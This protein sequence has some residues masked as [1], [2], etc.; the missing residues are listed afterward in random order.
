MRQGWGPPAVSGRT[1][2]TTARAGDVAY[3]PPGARG[4]VASMRSQGAS[5]ATRPADAI[6]ARVEGAEA[7]ALRVCEPASPRASACGFGPRL[8]AS[9]CSIDAPMRSAAE[10]A[11]GEARRACGQGRA[12]GLRPRQTC[13]RPWHHELTLPSWGFVTARLG[14]PVGCV[15]GGGPG[16]RAVWRCC[17]TRR[18]V[19][20]PCERQVS[21]QWGWI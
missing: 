19:L 13:A 20:G 9:F 10:A 12:A 5:H 18:E 15:G 4:R 11:R 17:A 7:P 21:G 16:S 14:C 8:W 1:A 3:P 2:R 6:R